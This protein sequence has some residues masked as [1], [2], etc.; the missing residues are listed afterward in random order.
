MLLKGK[1]ILIAGPEPSF[2]SLFYFISSSDFPFGGA[3]S[4]RRISFGAENGV[5]SGEGFGSSAFTRAFAFPF[6]VFAE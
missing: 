6:V 3:E 2:T 1:K 5:M 4:R